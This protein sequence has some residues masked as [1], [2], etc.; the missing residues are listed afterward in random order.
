[1]S[2]HIPL[3]PM[4]CARGCQRLVGKERRD[5]GVCA[6]CWSK[7]VKRQHE[8]EHETYAVGERVTVVLHIRR[9]S[10]ASQQER[11]CEAVVTELRANGPTVRILTGPV[12]GET[13]HPGWE[14]VARSKH[15]PRAMEPD[16][17]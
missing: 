7:P 15:Q 14:Q 17:L 10:G 13:R 9:P 6:K 1:M 11:T 4:L 16:G 5:T 8:E 3:P 12:A 2:K